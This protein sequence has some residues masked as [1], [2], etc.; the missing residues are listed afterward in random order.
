VLRLSKA[1]DP[2]GEVT[3]RWRAKEVVRDLYTLNDEEI[4]VIVNLRIDPRY[5]RPFLARRSPLP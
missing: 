1:G 5:E 4:A 3:A 2:K